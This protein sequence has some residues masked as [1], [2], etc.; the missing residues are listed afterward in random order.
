MIA[1]TLCDY[2]NFRDPLAR[3]I[4]TRVHR[5]IDNLKWPTV[6]EQG[7]SRLGAC[8][9]GAA[10][11]SWPASLHPRLKRSSLTWSCVQWTSKQSAT[12]WDTIL[13]LQLLVSQ[14]HQL[15]GGRGGDSVPCVARMDDSSAIEQDSA[16]QMPLARTLGLQLLHKVHV[17]DFL[18][19]SLVITYIWQHQQTRGSAI[20]G[21]NE[22]ALI[23]G[24]RSVTFHFTLNPFL[25]TCHIKWAIWEIVAAPELCLSHWQGLKQWKMKWIIRKLRP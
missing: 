3:Q 17:E 21:N 16:G 23:Q 11:E 25:V 10:L 4:K 13:S 12:R 1:W 6:A 2:Y 22:Q 7:K 15:Y 8:R 5:N 24:L 14:R 19:H 20:E 9:K 18:V